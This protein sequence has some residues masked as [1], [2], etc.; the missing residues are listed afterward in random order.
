LNEV[1]LLTLS[2][3]V[4]PPKGGN[5]KAES[6]KAKKAANAEQKAKEDAAAAEAREAAAWADNGGKGGKS[7]GKENA[8]EKKAEAAAAKAE[9]ERLLKEEEESI[10]DGGKKAAK[11][12]GGGGA[13][14]KVQP[15]PSQPKND[16]G[17]LGEPEITSLSASNIDDALDAL[18]IANEKTDKASQG[19]KAAG[20]ERHPER[21]FKAAFE[22]FKEREMPRIKQERP[23]M[24]SQQYHDALYKEFQ[25][26]LWKNGRVNV[27]IFL[28]PPLL[29]SR[30]TRTILSTN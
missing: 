14:K 2:P 3:V 8:A 28:I 10:P 5:S 16:F 29:L 21:R 15:P 27:G 18:S 4:M 17:D 13:K 26:S 25:V 24:R 11:K 20:L 9:R 19:S 6:G 23:G 30:N 12:E 7:K 1:T 22:A